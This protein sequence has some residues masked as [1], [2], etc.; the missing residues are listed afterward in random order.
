[1]VDTIVDKRAF[2]SAFEHFQELLIAKSGHSLRGFHEG[3]AAVW[4]SYEPRL[5]DYALEVLAVTEWRDTDVGT[6]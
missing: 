4:E 2:Q 6:G 5:R 3:L 1:M